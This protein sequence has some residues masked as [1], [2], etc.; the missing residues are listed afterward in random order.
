MGV[1]GRRPGRR[2]TRAEILA[3]A[4]AALVVEGYERSSL[5]GTARGAGVGSP[6]PRPPDEVARWIGPTLDRYVRDPLLGPSR[7]GPP[8]ADATVF[9]AEGEI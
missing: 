2:D 3:A 8:T 4:R 9:R 6:W 7:R 5:R 1:A